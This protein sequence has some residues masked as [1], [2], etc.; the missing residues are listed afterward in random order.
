MLTDVILK[1]EIIN[2]KF[3]ENFFRNILNPLMP[4]IQKWLD[5]FSKSYTANDLESG[6]KS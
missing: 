3:H 5:T 4:K 1:V 6:N 2:N